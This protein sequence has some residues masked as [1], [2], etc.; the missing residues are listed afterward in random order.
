MAYFPHPRRRTWLATS[1]VLLSLS[2]VAA[3][4][5]NADPSPA[6]LRI[7]KGKVA[8][9]SVSATTK[10]QHLKVHGMDLDTNRVTADT[11]ELL[12]YSTEEADRLRA[13]GF[14]PQVLI[15]DV[16]GDNKRARD[17]EDAKA[18]AL[19]TDPSQASTLPTGRVSYR[20]LSE[21][22]EEI[23]ELARRYPT[24]VKRFKMPHKS[25]LGTDIWGLEIS[26]N[27]WWPT[28][29][30]EFLMTGMHHSREWPTVELTMEFAHDLLQND[31]RDPRITRLMDNA[32]LVIVP[33][34]NPD[35][36][37]MSR[38]LIQEQKRK[39]CRVEDGKIPTREQCADPANFSKGVDPNRNYGAFWG[40]PGAGTGGTA[41]NYRGAAPFS[42]PEIQNMQWLLS[43]HQFTVAISNHTPDARVLR[44]PSAPNEPRPADEAAYD[45][46]GREIAVHTGW[47][48]GPWPEIYYNASGTT[49]ETAY[50]TSGTFAFT[51]ENTPGHSGTYTFHPPYPFVV[52]QYRG[53]GTYVGSNVR[54]AFLTAFEAAADA[55]RHS[56]IS[57]RAP[58]GRVLT[59]EKNFQLETSEV[60]NP[61][62]TTGAV[63][64]MPYKI[65][66]QMVTPLGGRFAWHVNPSVRPSQHE[67]VHIQE[68]YTLTCSLINGKVRKRIPV[69]VTRGE[70]VNVDLRR[71]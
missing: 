5:A 21:T 37:D 1:T 51:F 38:S 48:T 63:Q 47:Q 62:G 27:V 70:T 59:I 20:T 30:P 71:C 58:V 7:E 35:G 33:I 8:L 36:Y 17:T 50:Y 66:S 49:E 65:K 34:V 25:L 41:G 42:E 10:E 40:G 57:G 28:G 9:V 3:P 22:N 64:T 18:R 16:E 46:T 15:D 19:Q 69:T 61:D 54:E 29:K 39:N 23:A 6:P 4:A 60:T 12:L 67:S 55:K 53:T 68:S 31:R 43:N 24:K 11:I 13:A 44:V 45:A 26:R 56:V 14:T 32:K 52:D 2:L